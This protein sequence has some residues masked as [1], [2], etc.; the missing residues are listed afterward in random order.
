VLCDA[1]GLRE[2]REDKGGLRETMPQNGSALEVLC[3][4]GGALGGG[5]DPARSPASA[6][7]A[8]SVD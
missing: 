4:K 1:E 8:R 5:E 3:F 7:H 6:G 2:R